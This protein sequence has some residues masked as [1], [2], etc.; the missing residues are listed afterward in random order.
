MINILREEYREELE[1]L[2]IGELR[3]L[4]QSFDIKSPTSQTKTGLI[5]EILDVIYG[6]LEEFSVVE[7]RGRGKEGLDYTP[8]KA[9]VVY[10]YNYDNSN[11]SVDGEAVF[12]SGISTYS[13]IGVNNKEIKKTSKKPIK[14]GALVESIKASAKKNVSKRNNNPSNVYTYK[15]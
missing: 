12:A 14:S 4:G 2:S 15:K 13:T 9:E 8:S 1:K 3:A 10:T 11:A 5:D 6:E 7:T